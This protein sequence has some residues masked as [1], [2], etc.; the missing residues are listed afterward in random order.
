[1]RKIFLGILIFY[2]FVLY[3]YGQS[4]SIPEVVIYGEDVSQ[5]LGVPS[6]EKQTFLKEKWDYL[7]K[8]K[9]YKQEFLSSKKRKK[10]L[11]MIS[12]SIGNFSSNL[13]DFLCAYQRKKG[14]V[15]FNEKYNYT[16]GESYFHKEKNNV[17]Q[18][19]FGYNFKNN[20]KMDIFSSYNYNQHNLNISG[21]EEKKFIFFSLSSQKEFKKDL[22]VFVN[23]FYEQASLMFGDTTRDYSNGLIIDFS[24][25]YWENNVL[26]I[27]LRRTSE[28]LINRRNT[29]G[30]EISNKWRVF[31]SFNFKVGVR[32][33]DINKPIKDSLIS[34][35]ISFSVNFDKSLELY[36]EY[37][38][39][40]ELFS[41]RKLYLNNKWI[42][43]N[44]FLKP[45]KTTFVLNSGIRFIKDLNK[46]NIKISEKKFKHFVRIVDNGN[47]GTPENIGD[48]SLIQITSSFSREKK[49]FY[50]IDY[51]W[52]YISQKERDYIPYLPVHS[53]SGYLGLD[54]KKLFVK[55]ETVS[56]TKRYFSTT[57]SD[58][59]S[60]YIIFNLES[61]YS[62]LQNFK[63]KLNI[64]NILSQKYTLRY[65]Y[66]MSEPIVMFQLIWHFSAPVSEADENK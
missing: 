60:A 17:S 18:L 65:G 24:W 8:E 38:N 61:I 36:T 16:K 20:V 7:P 42:K 13:F 14:Y 3:G 62:I 12:P 30:A 6:E 9:I 2:F 51:V 39:D 59:L 40:L 48:I 25:P 53:L 33:K 34:P 5:V 10:F 37:F 27:K 45:Q 4:L 23:I 66:P 29:Y 32:F 26:D 54:T 44:T 63:L 35:L 55:L 31:P 50:G 47:T 56:S 1:M 15:L 41:F 57:N 19:T 64:E 49:F 22:S 46:L 11:L 28:K 58:N 43:V 52:S 21:N